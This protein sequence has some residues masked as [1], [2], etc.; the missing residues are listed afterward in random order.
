VDPGTRVDHRDFWWF[1]PITG[2]SGG[3]CR[4]GDLVG[5]GLSTN[6]VGGLTS[7]GLSTNMVGRYHYDDALCELLEGVC[8]PLEYAIELKRPGLSV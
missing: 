6:V 7:G 4:G 8:V 2:F 3:Q 5:G 1:Q